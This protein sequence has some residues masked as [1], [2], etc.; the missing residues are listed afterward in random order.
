MLINWQQRHQLKQQL[1]LNTVREKNLEGKWVAIQNWPSI[2]FCSHKQTKI[3]GQHWNFRTISGQIWNFRNFKNFRT[4]GTPED[5][6]RKTIA[7]TCMSG[8]NI[9]GRI[10]RSNQCLSCQKKV[11]VATVHGLWSFRGGGVKHNRACSPHPLPTD[12]SSR[13]QQTAIMTYRWTFEPCSGSV[14]STMTC[15]CRTTVLCKEIF[16]ASFLEAF[17]WIYITVCPSPIN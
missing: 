10:I 6:S 11:G 1:N 16:T 7:P 8:H 5:T 3:S 15:S 9:E 12:N 13:S 17:Y 4:T 2:Q 14:L